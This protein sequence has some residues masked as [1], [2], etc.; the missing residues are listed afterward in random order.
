MSFIERDL[1]DILFEKLSLYFYER[2]QR[3]ESKSLESEK[4]AFIENNDVI[5]TLNGNII[6][7]SVTDGIMNDDL[8]NALIS[9]GAKQDAENHN[10]DD[11][12]VYNI[13]PNIHPLISQ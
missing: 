7:N 12:L 2:M 11:P 8:Y 13:N 6:Y 3:K 9:Y 10:T 1:A 5:V 4:R